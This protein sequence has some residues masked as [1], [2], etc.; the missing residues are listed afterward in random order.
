MCTHVFVRGGSIYH[1]L[2]TPYNGPLPESKR[3][4]KL[5]KVNVE[6]KPTTI[7]IHRVKPAFM[8]ITNL[9]ITPISTKLSLDAPTKT[10]IRQ[11]RSGRRVHFPDYLVSL[12]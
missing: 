3:S 12:R 10:N 4:D 5:F 11:T 2:H 9:D 1:P 8:P 7:S 6:E